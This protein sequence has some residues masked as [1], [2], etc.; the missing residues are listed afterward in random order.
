MSKLHPDLTTMVETALKG[1]FGNINVV[2]LGRAMEDLDEA[3]APLDLVPV[4]RCE[5][6]VLS[7]PDEYTGSV[8]CSWHNSIKDGDEYC[9]KGRL[10]AGE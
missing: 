4:V 6:C 5:D 9:N 1:R 8:W 7:C 3:L 10:K 2:L